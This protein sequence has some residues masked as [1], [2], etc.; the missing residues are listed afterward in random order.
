MPVKSLVQ[1][2]QATVR[3]H[4]DQVDYV[5][6]LPY[7]R[8]KDPILKHIKNA[9]QLAVIEENSPQIV[10]EDSELWEAMCKRD[11]MVPMKRDP[12]EPENPRA[13]RQVYEY[14]AEEERKK[15][16]VALEQLGASFA[17]LN[18]MKLANKTAIGDPRKLPKAPTAGLAFGRSRGKGAG[19][20]ATLNF[21][22]GARTSNAVKKAKREAMEAAARKRLSVPKNVRQ[23]GNLAK[24]T[25]AP[26]SM[27]TE[28][29]IRAQPKY[30]PPGSSNATKRQ[31]EEEEEEDHDDDERGQMESRLLAAKRPRIQP[32]AMS[33]EELRP[34]S[35][36]SAE[37]S[38]RAAT[39][40]SEPRPST[41]PSK[42][43]GLFSRPQ[44]ASI[45]Q[46]KVTTKT[47]GKPGPSAAPQSAQKTKASLPGRSAATM[48]SSFA[49]QSA[50][51]PTKRPS[52][53]EPPRVSTVSK[54]GTDM[55]RF[56]SPGVE[57]HRPRKIAPPKRSSR[58]P[59]VASS[60]FG[61]PEPEASGPSGRRSSFNS[62]SSR[63]SSSPGPPQARPAQHLNTPPTAS[64]SHAAIP[65]SPSKRKLD[66]APTSGE[67]R[68]AAN[69]PAKKKK[70]D[71]FMRR[72]R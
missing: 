64:S 26:E 56:I 27:K 30:V 38:H 49:G 70:V 25:Q 48:P 16:A 72:K 13:W 4:I 31:R 53:P 67:G 37:G 41:T 17:G 1:L 50:S 20:G 29:R 28:A 36:G 45:Q 2:C 54:N 51:P 69:P 7:W 63:S 46:S 12:R 21:G 68:P 9:S 66:D 23:T 5:S 19:P 71:I 47:V 62:N 11:F 6:T 65:G 3:K 34:G 40:R 14:Y 43:R 52:R 10:G 15:E 22:G 58:S 57:A 60:I 39:P 55:S 33:D 32:K 24:V 61:S 42:P 35:S 8:I 18:K 44:S 59:S